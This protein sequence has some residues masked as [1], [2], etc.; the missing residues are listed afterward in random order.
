MS[1]AIEDA[2]ARFQALSA[3]RSIDI[4]EPCIPGPIQRNSSPEG[5][6]EEPAS[7]QELLQLY[8]NV[9]NAKCAVKQAAPQG[10]RSVAEEIA[11]AKFLVDLQA[12][13]ADAEHQQNEIAAKV[14]HHHISARRVQRCYHNY[15]GRVQLKHQ[16]ET[17]QRIRTC[18]A[19]RLIQVYTA[20]LDGCLSLMPRNCFWELMLT[21]SSEFR[22]CSDSTTRFDARSSRCCES[23]KRSASRR[24][25]SGDSCT[26]NAVGS[27]TSA[28]I[29][30]SMIRWSA[31][32]S[33]MHSTLNLWTYEM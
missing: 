24:S 32:S 1:R 5:E 17:L 8:E 12:Q 10:K 2:R 20:C 26:G 30:V 6:Q 23:T 25:A 7:R 16:V 31:R 22:P 18:W 33:G 15:R 19:I 29:E 27:A 9:M 13:R 11:S 28:L 14:H 21:P 3:Q 4:Q